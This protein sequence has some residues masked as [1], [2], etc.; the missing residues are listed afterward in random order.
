MDQ[1]LKYYH[2][3]SQAEL[4]IDGV[5]DKE[6]MGLTQE[7]FDIMA[8]TKE[9]VRD[10]Y[11]LVASHM[12]MG[13]MKFKQRPREE[14]AE[15]DGTEGRLSKLSQISRWPLAIQIFW[16]SIDSFGQRYGC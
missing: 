4:V 15:P 1:E 14:Q 8:Y 7:A 13:E 11:K 16:D 10:I 12:T 3:V 9:E 2:F 5:N 6:E